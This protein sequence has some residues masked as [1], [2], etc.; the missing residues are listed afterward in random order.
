MNI[1]TT[2]APTLLTLISSV[3]FLFTSSQL[4]IDNTHYETIGLK[5]FKYLNMATA[6]KIPMVVSIFNNNYTS[7]SGKEHIMKNTVLITN[8]SENEKEYNIYHIIVDTINKKIYFNF[9]LYYNDELYPNKIS[10][11][12][13]RDI[14][15]LNRQFCMSNVC[16]EKFLNFEKIF[17][18]LPRSEVY[19][20][21]IENDFSIKID[22]IIEE[23]CKFRF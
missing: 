2:T 12:T 22:N 3:D 15:F 18:Q 6:D 23:I 19:D 7:Y 17:R 13:D 10:R 21:V 11:I 9:H 20:Y 8:D 1:K 5:Q 4:S 16:S 14:I